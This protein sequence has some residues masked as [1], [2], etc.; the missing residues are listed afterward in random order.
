MRL[1][2]LL[3]KIAKKGE[4]G[5]VLVKANKGYSAVLVTRPVYAAN[6]LLDDHYNGQTVREA[7]EEMGYDFDF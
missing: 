2:C 3:D 6:F 7:I 4:A 1:E 5:I